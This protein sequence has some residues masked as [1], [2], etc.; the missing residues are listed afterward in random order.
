MEGHRD[1][2]GRA[3]FC[4][5][6]GPTSNDGESTKLVLTYYRSGNCRKQWKKMTRMNPSELR[7]DDPI[8]KERRKE[9]A[10]RAFEVYQ[11]RQ[12]QMQPDTDQ[13]SSIIHQ[14]AHGQTHAGGNHKA[15]FSTI[16]RRNDA[17]YSRSTPHISAVPPLSEAATPADSFAETQTP[18]S[19]SH[20]SIP[21]DFPEDIAGPS[22]SPGAAQSPVQTIT[23]GEG[24]K[25]HAA[26]ELDPAVPVSSRRESHIRFNPSLGLEEVLVLSNKTP[27]SNIKTSIVQGSRADTHHKSNSK[28][29]AKDRSTAI[30]E[31]EDKI[32]VPRGFIDF[33]KYQLTITRASVVS[34]LSSSG[35]VR[36]PWSRKGSRQIQPHLPQASNES[37]RDYL[38][39]R[40]SSRERAEHQWVQ[41]APPTIIGGRANTDLFWELQLA[42]S[43]DEETASRLEALIN[44]GANPNARSPNGE[45]PLHL[46]LRLG[47]LPACQVLLNKGADV[48]VKTLDG[49]SL[50]E[51]GKIAQNNAG[52]NVSRYLAIKTCRYA[53]REHDPYQKA[54]DA[55]KLSK[56]ITAP[57]AGHKHDRDP[58][59]AS[60]SSSRMKVSH[61][62]ILREH[63]MHQP[64]PAHESGFLPHSEDPTEAMPNHATS[65]PNMTYDRWNTHD[66]AI[67]APNPE[68][69]YSAT[70]GFDPDLQSPYD[71]PSMPYPDQTAARP[72][73]RT[74]PAFR[75]LVDFFDGRQSTKSSSVS[76]SLQS[77]NLD[78]WNHQEPSLAHAHSSSQTQNEAIFHTP[79]ARSPGFERRFRHRRTS[80]SL[81]GQSHLPINLQQSSQSLR[82]EF[83]VPLQPVLDTASPTRL[84]GYLT[85]LPTGQMALVCPLSENT[86]WQYAE[87]ELHSDSYSPAVVKII[88]QPDIVPF[89]TVP[90]AYSTETGGPA[91]P[92]APQGLT[93]QRATTSAT[94]AWVGGEPPV[95]PQ[96][97]P[98]HADSMNNN[99]TSNTMSTSIAGGQ[100]ALSDGYVDGWDFSRP[101]FNS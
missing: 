61:E 46:A 44:D 9:Q 2:H 27:G 95:Q 81:S 64:P 57:L 24:R 33:F 31:L 28:S 85:M 50:S 5:E 11:Q 60:S 91:I 93:L 72:A 90:H 89:P 78:G 52:D 1:S 56:K 100:D 45:T 6:V 20:F 97:A 68:A 71:M 26:L 16:L 10:I 70:S 99:N 30:A 73:G 14:P 8:K 101:G 82:H 38:P 80:R 35:S 65:L 87:Q 43:T 62:S 3:G 84:S 55:S 15:S 36:A 19:D 59:G 77:T 66:Q 83:G 22:A 69:H 18:Q 63:G 41:I 98:L 40:P 23:L 21:L 42:G 13:P 37:G 75:K 7:V 39:Q 96:P 74:S 86:S 32:S 47:N 76:P 34:A 92:A 12:A 51:Y 88:S 49:K 67:T 17:P 29:F 58:D 94:P 54:T 79:N 53:I 48:N 4:T 25:R